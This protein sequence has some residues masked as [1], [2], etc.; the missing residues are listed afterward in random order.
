MKMREI[1]EKELKMKHHL[2]ESPSH[3]KVTHDPV[4]QTPLVSLC[5][6][7]R[8]FYCTFSELEA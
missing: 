6:V 4:A 1:L 5:C 2:L 3:Q 7:C 8:I